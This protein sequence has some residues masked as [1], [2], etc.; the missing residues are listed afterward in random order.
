METAANLIG[1]DGRTLWG[2]VKAGKSIAKV[3]QANGVEPQT[4]IDALVAEVQAEIDAGVAAGRI[5]SEE[6]AQKSAGLEER[7]TFIVNAT[8]ES[9][10]RKER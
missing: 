10:R 4:I 9:D 3:A 1:I 7:F 8:F 6:A 2:E 5:S